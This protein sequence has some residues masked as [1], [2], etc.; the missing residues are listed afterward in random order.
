MVLVGQTAWDDQKVPQERKSD[1]MVRLGQKDEQTAPP[2]QTGAQWAARRETLEW[3]DL[4]QMGEV[5]GR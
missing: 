1:Q 3:G 4:S 2:A 5:A